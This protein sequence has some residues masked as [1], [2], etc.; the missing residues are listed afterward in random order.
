M[1]IK[2]NN[3]YNIDWL[4]LTKPNPRVYIV[5]SVLNSIF[6]G[7]YEDK[8]GFLEKKSSWTYTKGSS[9]NQIKLVKSSLSSEG[10]YLIY[11]Q[12]SRGKQYVGVWKHTFTTKKDDFDNIEVGPILN[13]NQRPFISVHP[14]SSQLYEAKSNF[15]GAGLNPPNRFDNFW[16]YTVSSL[17]SSSNPVTNQFSIR[18]V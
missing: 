7:K 13:N 8:S 10:I 14:L 16:L 18:L 12:H 6:L 3:Y 2:T 17:N 5:V 4:Y 11:E 9:L 15:T 1:V